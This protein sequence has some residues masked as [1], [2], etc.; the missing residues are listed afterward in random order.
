[1]LPKN[2]DNEIFYFS[3]Q[4]KILKNESILIKSFELPY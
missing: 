3:I 4:T 2:Y 1:M